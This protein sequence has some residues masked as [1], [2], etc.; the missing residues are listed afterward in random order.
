MTRR[1][2]YLLLFITASCSISAENTYERKDS[3]V[4][5]SLGNVIRKYKKTDKK[6]LKP[7]YSLYNFMANSNKM[8]DKKYDGG[9]VCGPSYNVQTSFS[10]GGAYTALYSFDH[11][12]STLQKS[13]LACFFNISVKGNAAVGVEG[14]N[15]MKHDKMRWHYEVMFQHNPAQFWGKGYDNGCNDDRMIKYNQLMLNVKFNW[16]WRLAKNLYAGPALDFMLTNTFKHERN[17]I[18][19]YNPD[20]TRRVDADGEPLNQSMQEMMIEDG[21]GEQPQSLSTAGFGFDIAYDSRDFGMNAYRGFYARALQLYFP[22]GINKYG[23]WSTELDF[24]H[25]IPVWKKCILA[26]QVH[27]LLNYG[28]DVMPWTR[29][30][31]PGR[32]GCLR[33]YYYGQYRDNN[34]VDAQIEL[35][36]RLKWRLGLVGWVGMGNVF[37][38]FKSFSWKHTL[39]N[40]GIG[41]RWEFKPRMN[42]RLEYGFTRSGGSVV[43]NM[44]EAF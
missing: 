38:D 32:R 35:R 11:N 37:H 15:Y 39:P 30:A 3:L 9:F 24:R 43:F 27:T 1:I 12:D 21:I 34:L 7:F 17:K 28:T 13:V 2:L 42:I 22:N 33:G 14:S 5:D 20:G 18:P 8:Q 26:M 19:V 29:M 25:Y 4:L 44:G 10:V 23:F 31:S 6:I 36:Q 40:Y 16:T 41:V